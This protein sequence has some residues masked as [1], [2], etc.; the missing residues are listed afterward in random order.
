MQGNGVPESSQEKHA[1]DFQS[2]SAQQTFLGY[3]IELPPRVDVAGGLFVAF[4]DLGV[5]LANN[6]MSAMNSNYGSLDIFLQR[7]NG[8]VQALF[9]QADRKAVDFLTHNGLY[10]YNTDVVRRWTNGYRGRWAALLGDISKAHRQIER[11]ANAEIN[12]R[13]DRKANRGGSLEEVSVSVQ[14]LT[15]C[16]LLVRLMPLQAYCI[17]PLTALETL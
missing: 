10:S 8:E 1:E 7:A 14:L 5:S 3:P 9:E 6:F 11:E 17:R 13:A 12:Y 4:R 2:S 16:L 15:E